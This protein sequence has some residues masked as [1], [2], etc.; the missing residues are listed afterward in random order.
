M[1]VWSSAAVVVSPPTRPPWCRFPRIRITTERLTDRPQLVMLMVMTK[2]A[3]EASLPKQI[4]AA[5][6]KAKCLDIMDLVQERGG[7]VVVTK[8]GKAVAKLVPI[9][10]RP[11]SLFGALRGMATLEDDLVSPIDVAWEAST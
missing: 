2:R 11:A 3:K 1:P 5:E 10:E 7:E 9:Q 8:R 4:S 6:F